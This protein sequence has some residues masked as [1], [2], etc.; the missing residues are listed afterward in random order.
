MNPFGGDSET[1]HFRIIP[2]IDRNEKIVAAAETLPGRVLLVILF[3][4]I[5]LLFRSHIY[6]IRFDWLE[7]AAIS[8]LGVLPGPVAL[9][10]FLASLLIYFD[11]PQNNFGLVSIN[12]E[13]LKIAN[14]QFGD[15][16]SE[17]SNHRV[18][19]LGLSLLFFAVL[20]WLTL[21]WLRWSRTRLPI[22]WL[23]VVWTG[24]LM[25]MLNFPRDSNLFVPGWLT[26][27]T[28][29]NC[30]F[31][32]AYYAIF[33]QHQ[34]ETS[35]LNWAAFTL[36]IGL[37]IRPPM[38]RHPRQLTGPS[39]LS[40]SVCQLKALKL[41]FWSCLLSCFKNGIIFFAF[42]PIDPAH[43]TP[44][45]SFRWQWVIPSS[46]SLFQYNGLHFIWYQ[47]LI[48]RWL[49]TVIFVLNCAISAG[50]VVSFFRLAGIYLP[51]AVYRPYLARSFNEYFRRCLFYYSEL[52]LLLFFYPFYEKLYRVIKHR[53]PRMLVALFLSLILGGWFVHMVLAWQDFF[54]FDSATALQSE[55]SW[56]PY[57]VFL[58]VACCIS[59][60]GWISERLK[61]WPLAIHLLINLSIHAMLLS[62]I[63][64][65][66]G[67]TWQD[68]IDYVRSMLPM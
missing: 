61:N 39:S 47:V 64:Y 57:F 54:F 20:N 63:Q 19:F 46:L 34:R 40:R 15:F 56:L 45:D 23:G 29:T 26:F 59:A 60:T 21:Q 33:T 42:Q 28:F 11:G 12:I 30:I 27:A 5:L 50:I 66:M 3:L 7:I 55:L 14:Q 25:L 51:R 32:T 62:F 58:A 8:C 10:I 65:A 9:R 17:L 43:P 2:E 68:R 6:F 22:F 41:L 24:A 1:S 38:L 35:V 52:I 67:E 13:Q 36:Q 16:I 4:S 53:R 44:F 49:Q 31:A 37:F 48:S 18:F